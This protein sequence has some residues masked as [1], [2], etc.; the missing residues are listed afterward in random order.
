VAEVGK[1][2]YVAIRK[3]A[4]GVH[5]GKDRAIAFAVATGITDL[6]LTAGFLNCLS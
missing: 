2:G 6:G 4:L 5:R 3:G 1:L